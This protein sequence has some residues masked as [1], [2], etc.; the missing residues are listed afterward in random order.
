MNLV[1][2]WTWKSDKQ[3]SFRRMVNVDTRA[4]KV[5]EGMR[6]NKYRLMV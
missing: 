3:K 1:E 4:Q 6:K 2:E 5:K